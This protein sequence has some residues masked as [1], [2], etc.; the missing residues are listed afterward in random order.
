MIKK[1]CSDYNLI[2]IISIREQQIKMKPLTNQKRR[3]KA[4]F[5]CPHLVC[6]F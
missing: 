2:K 6:V 1:K 3:V 4:Q 5:Y